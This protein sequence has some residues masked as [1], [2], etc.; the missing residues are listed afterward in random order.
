MHAPA[1][2]PWAARCAVRRRRDRRCRR[3]YAIGAIRAVRDEREPQSHRRDRNDRAT[4][5]PIPAL[6]TLGDLIHR[7]H[8]A[9]SGNGRATL[10]EIEPPRAAKPAV[11]A[12]IGR[13]EL[14][15]QLGVGAMGE[16]W[17]ARDTAGGA[18]VAIKLLKPEIAANDE[19][20][21][22]F[23]KEARVL[24]KVGS[25]YIANFVDLNEDRGLHYLVLELVSGGSVLGALKRTTRFTERLA[26]A[27]VADA[28]RALAEPHRL[29]IVHR[30]LKPDNMMFVRTGIE[31]DRADRAAHQARRFGIA[32]IAEE[33]R[34][35][36]R[37][38]R[39]R[40]ARR[41][42]SRRRSNARAP[43]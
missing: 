21:R 32:R 28:C 13:Y 36:R 6:P 43:A 30:D 39:R 29:G 2:H 27:I 26:L 35:Q 33:R 15:K 31:P 41:P 40:G 11:G 17:E 16:V 3:C 22:R 37:D 4:T 10:Q 7:L 1:H 18:N 12:T 5:P 8:A 23:R 34:Q 9:L 19:L 14:V 25:P 38:A 20:L 24:A 42:H